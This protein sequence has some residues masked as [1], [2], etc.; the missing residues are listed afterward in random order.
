MT[1][2][3]LLPCGLIGYRFAAGI[4]ELISLLRQVQA[5]NNQSADRSIAD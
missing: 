1:D 2:F 4:V 3:C 5:S